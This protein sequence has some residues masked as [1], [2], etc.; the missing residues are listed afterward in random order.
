MMKSKLKH[1]RKGAKNA[2]ILSCPLNASL[3][4]ASAFVRETFSSIS[5]MPAQTCFKAKAQPL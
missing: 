1:K 4:S 5:G 3:L 2:R